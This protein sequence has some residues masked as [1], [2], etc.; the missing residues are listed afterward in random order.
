MIKWK[1][2]GKGSYNNTYISPDGLSVL[3]VC[4]KEDAKTDSPE[5]SVRIWNE[6]NPDLS[7]PA[8]LGELDSQKKVGCALM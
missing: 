8:R 5:R 3:K 6:L 4:H 2:L 7:P 1:D